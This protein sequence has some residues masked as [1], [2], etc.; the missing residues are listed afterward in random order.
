MLHKTIH[1]TALWKT[2]KTCFFQDDRVNVCCNG[3]CLKYEV[4]TLSKYFIIN[5]VIYSAIYSLA[6]RE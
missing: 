5:A 1:F 2:I 3:G 4:S 6:R